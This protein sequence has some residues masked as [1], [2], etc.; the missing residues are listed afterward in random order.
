MNGVLIFF[1]CGSNTGYAITSCERSFFEMASRLVDSRDDIH[2]AYTSLAGGPSEGLP[3]TFANV[4]EFDPASRDRGQH[5]RLA[6]YVREHNIDFAFG[7]DQTPNQPCLPIMRRAGVRRLVSYWGAPMSSINRGL[8]LFLKRRQ[9]A[10]Y[11]SAPDHYVF[12]SQAMARTA[13]HG[14]GI[15][16]DKVS[17]VHLG[18]D[19]ERFAPTRRKPGHLQEVFG[20][21]AERRVLFYSGHMEERKGVRVLVEAAKQLA[22]HRGRR[23]FHWLILG[24]KAGEERPY[25]EAL[26]GTLA[27]DHVTFGGYRDDI[28]TI[29]PEC[30]VGTIASTG[31]DSFT[32]SAV[33]MASAGLPLLVSNLQ[34]L[35][36]TIDE[37][38]TGYTF[39]PGD[40][41][42]LANLVERMLDEPQHRAELGQRARTRVLHGFTKEAQVDSLVEISHR[43]WSSLP[44]DETSP[45]DY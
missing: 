19:A 20:I 37:G 12:E 8:K 45:A 31:W 2:F 24:N 7:F 22:D 23:D 11:R 34:G 21:P 26:E 41:R 39:P 40:A 29:L 32:M 33:E 16:E 35:V 44:E 4:L 3:A 5:Q 42:A 17:V 25:L 1:H 43:V 36:E 6:T 28:P 13:T 14:R 27:A 18:V 38:R 10:F 9:V 15:P 30:Y